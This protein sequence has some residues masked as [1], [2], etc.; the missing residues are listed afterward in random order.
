M[1]NEIYNSSYWGNG[2]CDNAIDWGV[3]YKDF[4]GCTP[5][6]QNIYSLSFDGV[7][8]FI[9]FSPFSL[10]GEFTLSAWV[11]PV[12]LSA[13]QGNIISSATSNANK[14]GISSASS[15]QVK[16]GG[17]LSTITDGGGNNFSI[18]VWQHILII[19]DSSNIVTVFRNGSAFGSASSANA[20]TGTYDSIGKFNNSQFLDEQLDEVAYWTSDQ[21]ANIASIYSASGAVDLSSLNPTAWYRM[22]DNGS[23]KS[24]QWLIPNNSNVANSRFSNYSFLFDGVD[25]YVDVGNPTSLQIT[26]ALSISAWVKFTGN[27]A[28]IVSKYESGSAARPK[29]FGLEGD[30]SGSSHSPKFFIY[31]SGT[32][33]ETPTSGK[34]VDDGN[35][36]HLLAVFNPSTYLRLYI[37]GNLEQENTTSIPATID[38]DAA[39]FVIGAI[40]SVGNPVTFFS[41]NIDEVAVWNSDQSAN[42]ASIYNSGVPTTITGAVAHWKMGEEATFVYNVNPEGTWTIPDQVASNDGTSNNTFLD[43]G[44]V[45]DAPNSTS[46][47]VSFNMLET[48]RKEDTPP[49]P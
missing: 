26:G 20:G 24:P 39:D 43:T 34:V 35:W 33:Y 2:V 13:N 14:I 28:P 36:H 44:R 18:G 27:T 12:S 9:G 38:N 29:S 47:A 6:F 37:D 10:S 11:K 30:R 22:G 16:L 49:T 31:N 8:D 41:G 7:D 42:V 15:V 1:A 48:D 3:V 19:R 32:I 46:N 17:T 23:Y 40:K 5:A 25:D 21:S 4:A 45:G